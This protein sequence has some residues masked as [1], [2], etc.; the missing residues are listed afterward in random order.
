M[1]RLYIFL[2]S[3]CILHCSTHSPADAQ[4]QPEKAQYDKEMKASI[5]VK[6]VLQIPFAAETRNYYF[7]LHFFP[8]GRTIAGRVKPETVQAWEVSSGKVLWCI[9]KKLGKVSKLLLSPNGKTGFSLDT[10]AVLRSFN[11]ESGDVVSSFKTEFLFGRIALHTDGK[12]LVV[13]GGDQLIY[14]NVLA[15]GELFRTRGKTEELP[16]KGDFR[17]DFIF[18]ISSDLKQIATRH[19]VRPDTVNLWDAAKKVV[20]HQ[21][22]A[23]SESGGLQ[24]EF[25]PCGKYLVVFAGIQGTR[26]WNVEK[27][28]E[29]KFLDYKDRVT[30]IAISPD[31]KLLAT[32]AYRSKQKNKSEIVIWDMKSGAKLLHLD[33][34]AQ[35]LTFS[36]KGDLLAA[37]CDD[38][39]RI[40]SITETEPK[41]AAPEQK[42]D[43]K[44]S[45]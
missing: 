1:K 3:I 4:E 23:K 38:S 39:I 2:M 24:A 26:I 11:A 44:N 32:T 41:K 28:T 34:Q 33:H 30:N 27:G 17:N 14:F 15:N 31:S 19:G 29:L 13:H 12:V 36:P 42:K 7:E 16:F 8:D 9:E 43:P 35:N 10:N 37:L 5:R 40:W 20:V 22:P 21:M 6:E 25:S 45:K 18:A